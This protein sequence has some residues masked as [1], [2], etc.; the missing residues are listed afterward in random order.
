MGTGRLRD[1]PSS[2]SAHPTPLGAGSQSEEVATEGVQD[3][4]VIRV[5]YRQNCSAPR[6]SNSSRQTVLKSCRRSIVPLFTMS[7]SSTKFLSGSIYVSRI[8]LEIR[9]ALATTASDD[10]IRIL[11]S[12]A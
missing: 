9:S 11:L 4:R 10:S 2:R 12:F 1:D 3:R 7:R 5:N 6:C 8:F